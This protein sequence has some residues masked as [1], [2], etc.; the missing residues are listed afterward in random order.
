MVYSIEFLNHT[1]IVHPKFGEHKQFISKEYSR[2][3]LY[4]N[5]GEM[6]YQ[7]LKC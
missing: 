5:E 4:Y 2:Q 7:A 1:R 3:S 6:G